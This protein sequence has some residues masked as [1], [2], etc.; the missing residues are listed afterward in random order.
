MEL[1]LGKCPR[2]TLPLLPFYTSGQSFLSLER[3]EG[4][5]AVAQLIESLSSMC[6]VLGSNPS[7]VNHLGMA[8]YVCKFNMRGRRSRS[9]SAMEF[10]AG[11]GYMSPDRETEGTS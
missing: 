2:P 4:T 3:G 11:P 10:K 5:K 6:K 1:A 7:I 9:F 8:T